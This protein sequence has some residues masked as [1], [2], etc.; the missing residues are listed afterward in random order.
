[1]IVAAELLVSALALYAM[2]GLLFAIAFLA[3]GI[4]HVDPAANGT[5]LAF[6]LI[7]LPGVAALWPFLL[8]RWLQKRSIAA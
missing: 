3:V 2:A 7:L 1:M 5:G 4:R 8:T 6:R